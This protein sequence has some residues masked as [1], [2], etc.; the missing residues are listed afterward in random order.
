MTLR[1]TAKNLV[2]EP[3]GL[4]ASVGGIGLSLLLVIVVEGMF[5]G[6]SERIVAYLRRAGADVWVMQA[7]VSNM[8]MATS[9]LR[10]DLAH[11][12][13][14]VPGVASA[15]PILYVNGFVEAGGRSWFSYVVGLR[16]GEERGGPWAMVRGHD[17]PER[18]EAVIP[19][20]VAR[21]SGIAIGDTVAVFGRR[22]TV[23]GIS[24]GTYSMANSI[25]FVSYADL[26]EL[27]FAPT[28]ASY[29]LIKGAAGESPVVLADRIR[30]AVPDV[31]AMSR[32]AFVERDRR[33][34]MQMGIEIIRLMTWIG[35]LVAAIIVAFT[36]YTST[37]RR[38]RELGI[39]KALGVPTGALYGAVLVHTLVIS[40]LGC[41]LAFV[42]AQAVRPVIHGL[43]PEVSLLYPAS[44]AVRLVFAT[45]IVALAASLVPARRIAHVD[46]A[47][48]FR[49]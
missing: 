38:T 20:V 48:V 36:A 21:K 25:T 15:T 47:I 19:D 24:A 10:A 13:E 39:A 40:S 6:E 34:A 9:L 35:S 30:H 49:D 28:A 43:V 27:L 14:A 17:R 23:V 3:G 29:L 31:N 44:T 26:S 33:M 5:A 2:Q 37:V 7:G 22:L 4:L 42:V 18:G 12:V 8:H 16:A 41:A 45:G 32:D 1:W 46:P 11:A